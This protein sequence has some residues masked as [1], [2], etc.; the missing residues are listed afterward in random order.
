M[1]SLAFCDRVSGSGDEKFLI[2]GSWD[3]VG[4]LLV[5]VKSVSLTLLSKDHQDLGYGCKPSIMRTGSGRV[6]HKFP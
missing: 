3:K 2:T 6:S 1:A 5:P 4:E